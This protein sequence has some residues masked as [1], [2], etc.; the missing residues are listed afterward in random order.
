MQTALHYLFDANVLL[1]K[2]KSILPN[3]EFYRLFFSPIKVECYYLETLKKENKTKEKRK[4]SI[5]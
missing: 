1:K 3:I 5:E 4:N 2:R